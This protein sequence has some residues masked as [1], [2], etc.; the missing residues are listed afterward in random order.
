MLA[1]PVRRPV[2]AV[3]AT[4]LAASLL[5]SPVG[6]WAGGVRGTALSPDHTTVNARV[7]PG[8]RV[9]ARVRHGRRLRITCQRSGPIASARGDRS[10]I[11]N[12]VIVGSQRLYIADVLMRTGPSGVL[13]AKLCGAPVP[14]AQP[15]PGVISG[16]CGIVSPV[17]RLAPFPSRR[18]FVAAA[19]P[20]AQAS[21][22]VTRVPASVT[23]GQAIL[24]TGSGTIA[25]GANNYFGIK[26]T[27]VPDAR[28]GTYT[29][30]V[31]G[32]G[33]VLRKTQEV[34]SGRSVTTIGAFRAYPSLDASIRD[35]GARLLANPV[36]RSAFR[37]VDDPEHFARVI[38]RHY[39]TDPRYAD[40]VITL[41]R[42]EQLTRYDVKA[43]PTPPAVPTPPP[44]RPPVADP[45]TAQGG[46][47][48]A[49]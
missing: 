47:A 48:A 39:A 13:V 27:A 1:M 2:S 28:S 40:K 46:G 33:C 23:L 3:V 42:S 10:S 25:A 15:V 6:A 36:Y 24:E 12:R 49:P 31:N 35:H 17:A 41:M 22:R 7:S 11:W 30:G 16:A 26:A 20:G 37:Y 14:Q 18:V 5:W 34:I 21:A 32:V 43:A 9:K 45:P 29:W 8:G 4:A 44:S 38:A 19:V